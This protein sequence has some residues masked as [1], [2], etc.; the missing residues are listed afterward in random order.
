MPTTQWLFNWALAFSTPYLVDFGPGY[1][2]LQSKIF[3]V[4]FGA[5]LLCVAFVWFLI[6]E[7]KG[8][9]LEEV[10]SMYHETR[11]ARTSRRWRPAPRLA[12]SDGAGN[13]VDNDKSLG[14]GAPEHKEMA[15]A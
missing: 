7:T 10:D 5:T 13:E 2:N 3:F 12:G 15:S 14:G 9:T 11:N 6:Y 4:W 1:A 8:L